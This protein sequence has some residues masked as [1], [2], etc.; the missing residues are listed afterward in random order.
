[1]A[2]MKIIALMAALAAAVPAAA[3]TE[4]EKAAVA[5]AEA[6][7]NALSNLE[8]RFLQVNPDGNVVE[9]D[10]FVA[11]PGKMRIQYDPPTPMLVVAD[12]V[13]LIYVDKE[14]NEAS[15]IDLDETPAG[16][17]LKKD[18]SFSDPGV[19]LKG[20]TLGPGTVEI[21]ATQKKAEHQGRVT[22]VFA[23]APFE[24]KQWRVLDAQNKEV[25]VTLFE[26]RTGGAI[27]KALFDYA[28]P[29]T[30]PDRAGD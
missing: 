28:K 30:D 13:W 5:R 22:F 10:L 1:M 20:V 4:T 23:D 12:G 9:G 15:Y 14:V 17:L 26:A 16:L 19:V 7:L 25:T 18:L 2:T 8:A 3:L 29:A 21:T 24:L 27:D 6:Y 11:R